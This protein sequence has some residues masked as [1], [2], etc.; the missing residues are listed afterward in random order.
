MRKL[1]LIGAMLALPA[2]AS[3]QQTVVLGAGSANAGTVL[4]RPAAITGFGTLAAT[5]AS[6]LLSTITTGPNSAVW[7]TTTGLI[8]VKNSGLSAGIAYV[9]PLGG[10]CTAA[11]GI[12]LEAGASYG[13]YKPATT[14]TVISASTSSVTAQW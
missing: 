13:F 6:A 7:P 12:P 5:N 14:M 10:T 9:C 3:A 2:M 4:S 8:Y 11:T 1:L